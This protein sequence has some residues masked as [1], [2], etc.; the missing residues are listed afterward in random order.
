ML[1][2]NWQYIERDLSI[3]LPWQNF[4]NGVMSVKGGG[5]EQGAKKMY[6]LQRPPKSQC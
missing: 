5:H 2:R 4:S 6:K 1:R 3:A